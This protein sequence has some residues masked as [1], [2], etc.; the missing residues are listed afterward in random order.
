M[1][2]GSGGTVECIVRKRSK[3]AMHHFGSVENLKDLK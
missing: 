1:R 2:F 3:R